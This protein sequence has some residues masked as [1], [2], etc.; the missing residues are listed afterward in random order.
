MN[1]FPVPGVLESDLTARMS[2]YVGRTLTVGERRFFAEFARQVGGRSCD[3]NDIFV[4]IHRALE[5]VRII[6]FGFGLDDEAANSILDTIT[7][8]PI[9]TNVSNMLSHYY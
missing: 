1:Q 7:D 2:Y 5:A 8:K 6:R 4:G 3:E 9:Q